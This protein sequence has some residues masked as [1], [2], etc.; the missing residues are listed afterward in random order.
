MLTLA[1]FIAY[2]GAGEP[3]LGGAWPDRKFC[4]R[5][6]CVPAAVSTVSD[7]H[8]RAAIVVALRRRM[9]TDIEVVVDDLRV[10]ATSGPNLARA[11]NLPSGQAPIGS[12][13]VEAVPE[14]SAR[15]DGQ[16]RFILRWVGTER[17]GARVVRAGAAVARV[18]VTAAHVHSTTLVSRGSEL[19][20]DDV[21]DVRHE[22]V[23]GPL[24]PWPTIAD[25]VG[26][27][28]LRDLAPDACIARGAI[29]DRPDVRTGQDVVAISRISGVE[30][31]AVMVAAE[32]G[33]AGSVIRVVN[34]QSRRAVKAR[35]VSSGLVEILK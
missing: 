32:S 26:S 24:R 22:I 14:P 21:V 28:A 4:A 10:M 34:R 35:I 11:Q 23:S 1:L 31:S 9:G 3:V 27:K 5:E 19:R 6:S 30:A 16:I 7:E 25:T 18:R 20:G 17:S 29:A 13:I 15:L 8:V 12:A 2:L 33:D